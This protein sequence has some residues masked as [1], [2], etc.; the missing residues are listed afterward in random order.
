MLI[1][2]VSESNSQANII[3]IGRKTQV[4]YEVLPI[5]G[6]SIPHYH[7]LMFR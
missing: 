3:H 7:I 1:I 4:G 6:Q 2:D 5:G